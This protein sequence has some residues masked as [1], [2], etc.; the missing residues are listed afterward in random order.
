MGILPVESVRK[1]TRKDDGVLFRERS[2][3]RSVFMTV[4]S[5]TKMARQGAICL[6][7]CYGSASLMGLGRLHGC[8]LVES[9]RKTIIKDYTLARDSNGPVS[10][11]GPLGL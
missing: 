4:E 2:F 5:I 10:L 11:C 1:T 9:V 7:L 3:T 6:M 8:L